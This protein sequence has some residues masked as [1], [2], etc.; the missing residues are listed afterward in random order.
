M[1]LLIDWSQIF[2][3]LYMI[4]FILSLLQ[5]LLETF[6]L[7]NSL[8]FNSIFNTFPFRQ[9]IEGFEHFN[10]LFDRHDTFKRKSN[11]FLV[12]YIQVFHADLKGIELI[13]P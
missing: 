3:V 1:E 13:V 8:S 2:Y 11:H 7:F 5:L 10:A 4:E 6:N 9:I 12:H